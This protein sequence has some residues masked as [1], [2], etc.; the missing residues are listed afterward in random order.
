MQ[1]LESMEHQHLDPI[2]LRSLSGL[3][4]WCFHRIYQL[5]DVFFLRASHSEKLQTSNRKVTVQQDGEHGSK[6]QQ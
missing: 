4:L 2:S 5:I 6:H 3:F 1:G